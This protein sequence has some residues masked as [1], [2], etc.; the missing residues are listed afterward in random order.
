MQFKIINS[1][2]EQINDKKWYSLTLEDENGQV[3]E[4]VSDWYENSLDQD[5]I[6]GVIE[7]KENG[8]LNFVQFSRNK[9]TKYHA[10]TDFDDSLSV[11]K[12]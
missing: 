7:E 11:V 6:K 2:P 5:Y 4:G 8:Y 3:F 10:L 12:K 9:G 1:K